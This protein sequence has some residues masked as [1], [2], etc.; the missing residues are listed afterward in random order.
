[1]KR[2]IFLVL[3]LPLCC[4]AQI[5]EYYSSIDFNQTGDAL[6]AE[7]ATLITDTQTTELTYTPGVWD[8]LE[9]ADEDPDNPDNVLLIYGYDDND[10]DPSTDR[11]RSKDLEC[12]TNSCTGLWVR[13]H[14][15]PRSLGNPNLEY[16]GPGSDAH[17]IRAIDS[18]RNG[19]RSNRPYT[20]G[21]GHSA[22]VGSDYFYPGDEWKGDV[23]RM[24]MYMYVRYGNRCEATVVGTGSTSYSNFGDMPNIFLEWNE[25]DPVS[26]YEM[27]RNNVLQQLEGNRNPFI[28]DPYLATMIWNGPAAQDTWGVLATPSVTPNPFRV[29]P[30][31]TTGVVYVQNATRSQ[32]SYTIYNE[33]G[34]EVKSGSTDNTSIDLSGNA[35]GMYFLNIST[36]KATQ[37]FKIM[38]R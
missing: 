29:Y 2:I 3:L 23:A 10:G 38:L 17:H 28:D 24:M 4:I 22:A 6:K 37:A 12:H 13:E 8:A 35:D 14:T 20:D 5:P 32:Y 34:Q 1:M 19:I 18:Q 7:L 33:L 9:Q 15:Y 30:T 21:S 16:E 11:S 27:N 36:G 31:V 25:E 26:E